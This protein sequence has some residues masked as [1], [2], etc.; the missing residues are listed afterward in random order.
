MALNISKKERT[1]LMGQKAVCTF[2]AHLP[3]RNE[4]PI[5]TQNKNCSSSTSTQLVCQHGQ[6]LLERERNR[7]TDRQAD[8]QTDRDRETEKETAL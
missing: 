8:R 4:Q 5:I 3:V 1:L 6:R 7:E 2:A